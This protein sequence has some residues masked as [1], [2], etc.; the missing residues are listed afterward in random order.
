MK[1]VRALT[2]F[3]RHIVLYPFPVPLRSSLA[4]ILR[5]PGLLLAEIGWRWCF[6]ISALILAVLAVVRLERVLIVYPE[7]QEMIASRSPILIAQAILEIAHRARPVAVRLGIVLIPTVVLLWIIAATLGRGYVVGRL[8]S[9]ATHGPRWL[10]LAVLNSLR[11]VTVV[12]L[13]IAYF[14]CSFAASLVMNSY[15]PNYALGVLV[16]LPLFVIALASWAL[17]Q[18]I[19]STACIY[20]ARQNLGGLG[21]LRATMQLL[22]ENFRELFS[23]SAQNSSVRTLVA[24]VFTLTAL[25]PLLFYRVPVLFWAIELALLLAYCVVSDVLLLARLIAYVDVMEKTPAAVAEQS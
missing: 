11:V 9:P 25:P 18:W 8:S 15:A 2:F 6:G 13:V 16:F 12:L 19:V 10:A 3:I 20:A 7:E 21:A 5:R 22:R 17:L 1:L 23:I 4:F 24:I 14:G